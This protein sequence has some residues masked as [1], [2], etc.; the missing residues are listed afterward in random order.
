MCLFSESYGSESGA[1]RP[2]RATR[3]VASI[4]KEETQEGGQ[5]AADH[6][7]KRERKAENERAGTGKERE[8]GP[9]EHRSDTS[10]G[11][12]EVDSGAS[13]GAAGGVRH[14]VQNRW[15]LQVQY[16]SVA[17][18]D[19]NLVIPWSCFGNTEWRDCSRMNSTKRDVMWVDEDLLSECL[20]TDETV[21]DEEEL[22]WADLLAEPL[23]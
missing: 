16:T 19:K 8:P 9:D 12:R 15:I 3:I 2:V 22:E 10:D 14:G 4:E 23:K 7:G 18:I 21:A 13:Y 17:K 11:Q 6:P 5:N 1:V 20:E